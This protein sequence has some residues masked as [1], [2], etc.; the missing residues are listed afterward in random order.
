MINEFTLNTLAQIINGME[1]AIVKL[2]KAHK[3]KDSEDFEKAKKTIL[4]FQKKLDE[5][6]GGKWKKELKMPN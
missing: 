2:E 3:K 5:E 1:D 4:V 6:L